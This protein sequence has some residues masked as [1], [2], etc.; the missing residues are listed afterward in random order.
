MTERLYLYDTTLRDGQQTHGAQF[1]ILGRKRIARI[2]DMP[3]L[4]RIEA[5]PRPHVPDL[6]RDLHPALEKRSRIRSGTDGG[7]R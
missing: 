3:G 6:I 7:K 2:L 4:G 1:S 5:A